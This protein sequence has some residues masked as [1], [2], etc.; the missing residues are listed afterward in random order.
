MLNTGLR[1]FSFAVF[2][3][4]TLSTCKFH[5]YGEDLFIFSHLHNYN[6]IRRYVN[7]LTFSS[8]VLAMTLHKLFRFEH[9]LTH[10]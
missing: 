4:K 8:F 5:C 3:K 7:L 6:D 9:I 10:N 2:F 1:G